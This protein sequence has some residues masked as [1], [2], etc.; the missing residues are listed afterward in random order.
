MPFEWFV[1]RRYLKGTHRGRVRLSTAGVTIG[2]AVLVVVISVM[3]GFE[4]DFLHKMLGA[5]GPLRLLQTDQYGQLVSIADYEDWIRRFERVEG[6]IGVSPNI[7]QGVMI[8]AKGGGTGQQRAQFVM[9]RGIEPAYEQSVS[10]IIDIEGGLPGDWALLAARDEAEAASQPDSF[11]PF[12]LP[13]ELPAVFIGVELAKELYDLPP[14]AKW[15]G[16]ESY[17]GKRLHDDVIGQSI[18][19]VAPRFTRDPS[20]EQMFRME[21]EIKG[22]FKTGFYEFDKGNIVT[23][24]ETARLLVGMEPKTVQSLVFNI[25][26]PSPAATYALAERLVNDA[27]DNYGVNFVA[28]PWMRL[29]PVLLEAVK[30]EKVVMSAI[31]TLLLLVAAF[32]IA[33]T[34]I[35]TVLEKTREIGTLMAMGSRRWSIMAIFVINGLLVGLYGTGFG[36]LLG[37]GICVTIDYLQINLPGGGGVYILDVLPV[38]IRWWQVACIAVFSLMAATLAGVIPAR[39]AASLH[40]VEALGHE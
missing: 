10:D 35:M 25:E 34:L 24:L 17:L 36:V 3:N 32:G 27:A 13:I 39:R 18:S 38:E 8:V 6:V 2:V 1:A 33:S 14:Q 22:I 11:D 4:R 23:S 30:I 9:S 5:F 16:P 21:A 26:D 31:L 12:D 20:G 7:E 15:D 19:L 40:P 37:V 28:N 29:N